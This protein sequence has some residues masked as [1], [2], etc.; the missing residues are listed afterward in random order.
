M[1][2]F[3][4]DNNPIQ[5]AQEH[6]DK[7]VVKMVV[8][9]A[10]L[11]STADRVLDNSTTPIYKIA[12]KNHPSAIWCRTTTENYKWLYKL[13]IALLD[14]YEFRYEKS[15]KCWSLIPYLTRPPTNLIIGDFN[16]PPPAMPDEYKVKNDVIQSYRNY[17]KGAK[18][19]FASWRKRPI[20]QWFNI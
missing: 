18:Y 5:C 3:Y 11:L 13:L 2:I 14:E 4:L 15:H 7:H 19:S 16:P 6:C 12:H 20:P 8:E 9:T 17:Y 1:N 10:Q